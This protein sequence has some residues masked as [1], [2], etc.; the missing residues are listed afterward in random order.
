MKVVEA[1]RVKSRV[2]RLSTLTGN[3]R[4]YVRN[5]KR[6]YSLTAHI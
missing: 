4:V 1:N 3:R 2:K 5:R 6:K